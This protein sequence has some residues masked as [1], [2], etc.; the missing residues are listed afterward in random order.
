MMDFP[1]S[2]TEDS[3][4]RTANFS[5]AEG[6]LVV[7]DRTLFR[8][9]FEGFCRRLATSAVGLG[10]VWSAFVCL[11]S[12]TCRLEFE[13]GRFNAS[14]MAEWFAEAVRVA[15]RAKGQGPGGWISLRIDAFAEPGATWETTFEG[16]GSF[17][18]RHRQL[19]GRRDLAGR[20]A[21][22]LAEVPGVDSCRVTFW[23]GDLDLRF[24]REGV[25]SS[26]A[27]AVAER[28]TRQVLTA[29]PDPL[30]NPAEV[31]PPEVAHGLRRLGYLAL[32]A[33]S[34]GLTVVGLIVPGMPTVPFLLA[35]SYFLV[36]S[37]P[38]W[39]DRLLRSTF[40]GPIL[41]DLE[42]GHG[43]RLINKLKLIA[44]TLTIGLVTVLVLV[45]SGTI[46]LVML[47]ITSISLVVISRIP[48]PSEIAGSPA[49]R[50][51]LAVALIG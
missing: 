25:C 37:S 8:P 19:V 9:G 17:R 6:L 11:A 12:G 42:I 15:S 24:T 36:R 44:F 47:A 7:C 45:P 49:P 3:V 28:V 41:A 23:G 48:G 16:R 51:A 10:G 39:N 27:L 32:A 43:L 14:E 33:G 18:L 29:R 31:S 50:S 40:F 46:L 13:P 34:F 5:E 38:T 22:E 2:L 21:R 4:G 1:G 26:E 30:A 20:I 35:T